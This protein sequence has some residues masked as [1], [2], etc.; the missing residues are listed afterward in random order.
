MTDHVC[1]RLCTNEKVFGT[2][3]VDWTHK[4]FDPK[5]G[6]RVMT[7]EGKGFYNQDGGKGVINERS[8]FKDVNRQTVLVRRPAAS[9]VDRLLWGEEETN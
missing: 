6:T 1:F 2:D 8:L 3:R 9:S 4:T 5:T 7:E